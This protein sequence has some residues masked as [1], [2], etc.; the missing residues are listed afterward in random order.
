MTTKVLHL[1]DSGGLYGAEMMLLSL[2]EEQAKSGIKPL[3]L[4]IGLPGDLEKPIEKEAI[5]RGLPVKP[6]RMKSGINPLKAFQIIKF[7]NK[8]SFNLMHSHGYKFNILLGAIPR[9]L[10][11]IPLM[12]TLHGYTSAS[13]FSK[14]KVY[15]LLERFL[16]KR[17]DGVVYVSSAI[18][19]NPVLKGYCFEKETVIANGI[20][21]KRIINAAS[22]DNAASIQNF[23]S[24]EGDECKYIGAIGR[25]SQ[26]KGFDLLIDAFSELVIDEPNLRLIIIGEGSLRSQ[27][28]QK[29]KNK[30]LQ[31]KIKLSGFVSPLYRLMS[32]LDG[33]VMPSHT[34][35]LPITLLEACILNT[36]IVASRVG[37]IEEVLSE[38]GASVT[39][40]PG[41]VH[42]IRDAI[43]KL[44]IDGKGINV[45]S[46]NSEDYDSSSMSIR[47]AKFYGQLLNS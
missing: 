4:S 26:E 14:M 2:V 17:L 12:T 45:G 22:D 28:E 5:R 34:E 16:L 44:I 27:L 9:F 30:N 6:F 35:G 23:F 42:E 37:S 33:L 46:W 18:K 1:I 15:Q 43:K 25:L 11:K 3:I 47:Y 10:R 19:S 21:S 41:D 13:G 39:V 38:Y 20:D 8:E 7:A 32:E 29:I 36:P 40:D 24:E 31:N